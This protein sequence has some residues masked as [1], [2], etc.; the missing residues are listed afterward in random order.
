MHH[1]RTS[2]DGFT[3]IELAIVLV[4]LGI[5]AAI[6]I[7][8]YAR[9]A[10]RA[11]NVIVRENLHVVHTGMEM[12]AVDNSGTYPLAADEPALKALLPGG[13]YP[14]S[15]FTRAETVVIW[16]ADPGIPGEIGIENLP[17]GGYTLKGY[18][19]TAILTPW[20]QVGN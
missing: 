11:K 7:P 2:K 17:G 8:N 20:I 12:F 19:S 10:S 9:F 14:V 6:F 4:I 16:G 18:G 5:L 13:L 1:T 3:L 15:P